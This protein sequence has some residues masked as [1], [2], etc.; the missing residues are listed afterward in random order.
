[1]LTDD[2]EVMRE[3]DRQYHWIKTDK[4]LG[5]KPE[6]NGAFDEAGNSASCLSVFGRNKAPL[7]YGGDSGIIQG[8]RAG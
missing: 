2:S 7:L 4:V 5:L 3:I 6:G 8:C 1:M